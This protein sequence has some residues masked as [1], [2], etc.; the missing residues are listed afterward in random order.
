ME[1]QDVLRRRRMVRTYDPDRPVPAELVDRI[2]QNGLRAPSAGFSQGWGFLVL[3]QADDIARF[4]D[5][6]R[7]PERPENW[8]AANVQAPLLIVAHSDKDAYLDRYAQPDKGFTDRSDEWW[9]APYWDIDAG[10][11]ALL[12]LLTAV[13]AGL[14]ACF[15]GM[16]KSRIGAYREAFGVPGEFL[17]IGIVSIG[18]SD[19]PP[20]DLR[21]RRRPT[22]E[23]VHRGR[24]S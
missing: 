23:V 13:D 21:D 2:V 7:P 3:D 9:P 16:P 12:M 1:F 22:A 24:W 14:G 18:Y 19:E 17:P 11:A 10:F 20:R 4:R 6:V 15:F 5:A 8:F